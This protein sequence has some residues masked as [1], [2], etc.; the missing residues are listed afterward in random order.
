MAMPMPDTIVLIII[1][2]MLFL[3]V[4]V[5]I[6]ACRPWRFLFFSR[7]RSITTGDLERPLVSHDLEQVTTQNDELNRNRDLEGLRIQIDGRFGS[8]VTHGLVC[9]QRLPSADSRNTQGA[10]FVPD[11][12]SS[13]DFLVGET[14]KRPLVP[15]R[16]V[17]EQKHFKEESNYGSTIPSREDLYQ[18]SVLKD[19]AYKR[20]N[21]ILEV[22][23]GPSRGLFFRLQSTSTSRLPL[24]V[25]RVSPSDLLL[26]DPES[27]KWELVDMGSLN[28]TLWNSRPIH[29]SSSGSRHWSE[30]IG[31][32]SGDI[33][34]FG[35]TSKI[36]VQITHPEDKMPFGIGVASDPMA[37][38]RGG[39][40]LPMEDVC[41]Y[42][43]PL[44]GLEQFGLFG[45]CD[46]HGGAEAAKTAS[47]MLPEAIAH[48]LSDAKKRDRVL[49]KCDA[50]DILRDAFFKTEAA[51][52]HQ[53]E[54]CTATVLLVWVDGREELC[55]QC[56]NVGDSAC[57]INISGKQI[58]MTE[59]HRVSSHMERLRLNE[60]GEPLK[61]GETRLCG[62]NL[63]RMLGDKFLKEQDARFSSEPFVSQVVRIDKESKAFALLASDGLWDVLSVKK[64]V[65]LIL[66]TREKCVAEE[67]NSAEKIANIILNMASSKAVVTREKIGSEPLGGA[68]GRGGKASESSE[69]S[70][71]NEEREEDH[72]GG[73]SSRGGNRG[74][75]ATRGTRGD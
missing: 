59:D 64:V 73:S 26:N 41:Y 30:P 22:I 6:F 56:A 35:T 43:W 31:L 27:L 18:E 55:A 7:L 33:I 19:I 63:A 49:S 58:K 25:G 39:K 42:Q 13:E 28:G 12:D 21:L 15:N 62:L 38:R 74:I 71:G 29:S 40:K 50:S 53:Y 66:Q 48:T 36:C 11:V 72:V 57:V 44:P 52:H 32:S 75:R 51:L 69:D 3:V 2:L 9:K 60:L 24:T 10:S 70:L 67:G 16:F 34:T 23:S 17:E 46:G 37:L 68:H 5:F 65:Q 61:D 4:L 45:I 47:K 1:L 54:G 20:S 14:L 8:S